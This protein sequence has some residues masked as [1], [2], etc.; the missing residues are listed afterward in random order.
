M[1]LRFTEKVRAALVFDMLA[2][3]VLREGGDTSTTPFG[4]F[5]PP[6]R[7]RSSS[8]RGNGGIQVILFGR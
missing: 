7:H 1:N 6:A 5:Q 2:G 3:R 8:D 4:P